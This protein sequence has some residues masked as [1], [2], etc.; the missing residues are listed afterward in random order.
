MPDKDDPRFD[1]AIFKRFH[2]DQL[3]RVFVPMIASNKAVIGTVEAGYNRQYRQYIYEQDVRLL[4]GFVG[5]AVRALEQRQQSQIQKISHELSAPLGGIRSNAS[6][7]QRR[8]DQ[9]D[10]GMV[11]R[12]LGDIAVD[13]EILLLAVSELEYSLSGRVGAAPQRASA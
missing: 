8:L 4:E 5:Y 1:Q 13:A 11:Q 10:A 12:K 9:L 3:I 2:H 7:L 6:F